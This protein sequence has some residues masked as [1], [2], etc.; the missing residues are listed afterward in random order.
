MLGRLSINFE[1]NIVDEVLY[2][3]ETKDKK[4]LLTELK[5][6]LRRKGVKVE[7]ER[8]IS[9][10][11]EENFTLKELKVILNETLNFIPLE[12]KETRKKR[13]AYLQS[14]IDRNTERDS[15]FNSKLVQELK[16]ALLKK[17]I[18]QKSEV[19]KW[20][21]FTEKRR[22][23]KFVYYAANYMSYLDLENIFSSILSPE[24]LSSQLVK[25]VRNIDIIKTM[26]NSEIVPYLQNM[27][28][29]ENEIPETDK[30]EAL[31][32]IIEY[33]ISDLFY[34]KLAAQKYFTL[35]DLYDFLRRRIYLPDRQ[36]KIGQKA[37]GMILAYKIFTSGDEELPCTVRIPESY[38]LTTDVFFECLSSH[39]YNFSSFKHRLKDGKITE[40]E[41]EEEY[42][43][44]KELILSTVMP[45]II[46]INLGKI[47][48]KIGHQ[49]L[50]VRSSS[51]LEDSAS[52]FSGKY[53]SY[54]FANQ[55]LSNDPDK[56]I[57]KRLDILIDKILLVYASALR[58]E[59]L[60]YRRERGLLD[61][62]ERMSVLIQVVEGSGYGKYFFPTMAGVGLSYNNKVNVGNINW[63]DPVLRIGMGLGTGIVDMKGYQVKVVYPGNPDYSTILNYND[64]LKTSQKKIDILNLETD[65]IESIS[66]SELFEYLNENKRNHPE[67]K[68]FIKTI[69]KYFLST[70]KGDYLSEGI[71]LA[72]KLENNTHYFTFNGLKK[73]KFYSSLGTMLNTLTEKYVPSD[74]EFLLDFPKDSNSKECVVTIVQCRQLTGQFDNQYYA[75]PENINGKD[76]VCR[77]SKS[78]VNGYAPNIDYVIYIDVDRY[79]KLEETNMYSVARIIGH[80]NKSLSDSRFI[81][82]G[83]GRWGSSLTYHG[84]K[85]TYTEIYQTLALV[86]VA[87][88]ISEDTYTEPSL[89]SHFGNDVRE[90]NIINFSINPGQERTIFNKDMFMACPNKLDKFYQGRPMEKWVKDVI[91]V[92]DSKTFPSSYEDKTDQYIH[93]ISNVEDQ[94]GV[95]FLGPKLPFKKSP[96]V[97]LRKPTDK[98]V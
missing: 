39:N 90:S 2:S 67:I 24:V 94:T 81:L 22:F 82:V 51:L 66:R 65:E 56:D 55:K 14:R 26:T 12:T 96:Q 63:D 31:E 44:V 8:H 40:V 1:A 74:M 33:F 97:D 15:K 18:I 62:D 49:P 87:K 10:I 75:I 19:E 37:A 57:E 7:Q 89:G 20:K 60:I 80:L 23:G 30:Q 48:K 11:V 88:K 79:Y 46:R 86:E 61:I 95:I 34:Y 5:N 54:F 42:P 73:T 13:A 17:G 93:V 38:Y 77:V 4:I 3:L 53:D 47:L 78:V 21:T 29:F 6:H 36:G 45:D 76:I 92:I 28:E 71:G 43:Y 91:T 85:V 41:L 70:A 52:A 50:I 25:N 16:K 32:T 98:M 83:P 64:L 27:L 69:G 59:A 68:E 58:P 35:R 72:S 9:E 84:V